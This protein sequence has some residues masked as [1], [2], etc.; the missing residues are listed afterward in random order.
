M[1]TV[2]YLLPFLLLILPIQVYAL[3]LENKTLVSKDDSFI[4]EF[5]ENTVRPLLTKTLVIPNLEFGIIQLSDQEIVLEP[6]D[7]VSVKILGKSIAIISYD[8]P[9]IIYAK[10]IGDDNFSINLY[11]VDNCKF[12]K[13]TFTATLEDSF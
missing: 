3:D 1:K 4:I 13:H 2:F 11:I 7:N 5:G 8:N 10:N 6:F 9:V 12:S